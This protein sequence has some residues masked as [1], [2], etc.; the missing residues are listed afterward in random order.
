MD[1]LDLEKA[2]ASKDESGFTELLRHCHENQRPRVGYA[3]GQYFL[4]GS[5][6]RKLSTDFLDHYSICCYYSGH[7]KEALEV[8]THLLDYRPLA[9]EARDRIDSNRAFCIP[10]TE[11]DYVG[12]PAQTVQRIT[13]RPRSRIPRVTFSI[14]T[15][16]RTDLFV[17]TM[18]SFLQCCL[19]VDLIDEWICVD[20]MTAEEDR[21]KMRSL[22]PFF[23]FLWKDATDRGHPRSMNIIRKEVHTPYLF[24]CEDDWQYFSPKPVITEAIAVLESDP[25]IGQILINRNY[26]EEANGFEISGGFPNQTANGIQYI[27]HEYYPSGSEGLA[28]LHSTHRLHNAYWPHFSLRP[29]LVRMEA[30]DK[31]GEFDESSDHFELDYASRYMDAGYRSCFFNTVYCLHIG[32]LTRERN[33]ESRQNAYSLNEEIQFG[34]PAVA[35]KPRGDPR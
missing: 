17:R 8:M 25:T 11:S 6:W 14:T 13:G 35:T 3:L 21:E 22:Y 4:A 1:L 29:S 2:L 23:R 7:Q 12:Y 16:K 19:D 34:K 30:W 5:S 32:R 27:L 24:H 20:D 18:N 9:P 31:T 33:D 28:R 10:F 15:C 26:A